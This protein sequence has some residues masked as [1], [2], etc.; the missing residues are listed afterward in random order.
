MNPVVHFEMPY[1]DAGRAAAFYEQAFGWKPNFMGEKMG[2]YLHMTTSCE[3]A[4]TTD[5]RGTINGGMFPSKPDFPMQYPSVVI[6][7]DEIRAAMTR[8]EKAGGTVLGDPMEIPGIGAYV[9]FVDTEGNRNS[10][11]Q[12]KRGDG[13]RPE[14]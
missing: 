6:A 10:V 7:V 8:I 5:Y 12:P 9:A 13:E 1:R 11:L 4:C 2:D 14:G 3:D